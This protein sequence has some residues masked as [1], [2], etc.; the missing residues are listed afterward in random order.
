M[1]AFPARRSIAQ[2][3]IPN[4]GPCTAAGLNND[5]LLDSIVAPVSGRQFTSSQLG[6]QRISIRV[7]NPG[8]LPTSSPVSF[9][10][11]VN[12]GTRRY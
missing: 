7:R 3:I 8:S 9:S 11:Q 6:I 1:P 5:L 4:G 12:G 2:N 10:Y